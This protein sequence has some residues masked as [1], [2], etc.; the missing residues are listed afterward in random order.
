MFYFFKAHFF[1]KK[2][3]VNLRSKIAL[4]DR[5]IIKELIPTFI[6]SMA[7]CS[8]I[9]ELVG[10]SFE[11]IRFAIE[12]DLPVA[13]AVYIHWLKLPAFICLVLPFALLISTLIVYNKLSNRSEIIALQSLGISL[14][15]LIIPSLAIACVVIVVMFIL[16]ELIVPPANYKA[17]IVL[18]QQ[19]HVDRT[20][21]AKYNKEEIIYQEFE[22]DAGNKKLKMLFFAEHFDGSGMLGITLLRFKNRKIRQI[23]IAKSA[24]WNEQQQRWQLFSGI[25]NLLSTKGKYISTHEFDK[26]SLELTKN[27]F[28]YANNNRDLREMNIIELYRRLEILK[29]TGNTKKINEIEISI[30]KRYA[31]PVSCLIFTFLGSALGITAKTK[32]NYNSFG[33][34]AIVIFVY[35]CTQFL[36][37]ALS[38]TE[39]IS[40]FW[41][42]WFPNVL[43]L[44]IAYFI[45]M[46]KY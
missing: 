6:F 46:R 10:I 27:I 1:M 21:L 29:H 5:Y 42:V 32:A 26:L 13:I 3:I 18:E 44:F 45:L 14:Y 34:A 9:A 24:Q 35:S 4:L 33:I 23:I 36:S 19:L 30:Q 38:V 12:K 7:I 16:Q 8:I 20:K 31:A 41:G 15:R 17:A 39:V 43:G 28:D 37:V 2:R 22:P 40:I 25:L 11:E